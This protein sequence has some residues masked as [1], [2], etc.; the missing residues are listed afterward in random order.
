MGPTLGGLSVQ[1]IGFPWT[2]TIIAGIN[3]IF[4]SF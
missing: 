3:V 2:T 4:V 1:T